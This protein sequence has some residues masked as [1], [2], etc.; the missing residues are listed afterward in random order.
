M[1]LLR[2]GLV[3]GLFALAI[4]NTSALQSPQ[5][6]PASWPPG[7]QPVADESPALSPEQEMKTFFLPP[8]YHAELVASEPMVQDPIA[9]DW[10]ADGRLW[11]IEMLGYMQDLP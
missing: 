8:G 6:A 1:K 5:S 9:I 4:A 2:R 7:L 3:P 11:V 10:D